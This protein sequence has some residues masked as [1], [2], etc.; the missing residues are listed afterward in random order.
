LRRASGCNCATRRNRFASP[1]RSAPGCGA[2]GP[3]GLLNYDCRGLRV[4]PARRSQKRN[5]QSSFHRSPLSVNRGIY[6]ARST[7]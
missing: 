3:S 4:A 6:L 2:T 1:R 5:G 7:A